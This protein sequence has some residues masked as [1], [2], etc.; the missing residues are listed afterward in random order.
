VGFL[1]MGSLAATQVVGFRI[2]TIEPTVL[3]YNKKIM[4]TVAVG[5]QRASIYPWGSGMGLRFL[6]T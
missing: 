2:S 4:Q 1:V 5:E 6:D 3:S